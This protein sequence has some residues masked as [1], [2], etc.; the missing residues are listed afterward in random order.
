MPLVP[1]DPRNP[2]RDTEAALPAAGGAPALSAPGLR[3]GAAI[4]AHTVV[5]TFSFVLVSLMP[6]F[7]TRLGLTDPQVALLLGVGSVCSGVIQPIVAWLSD[8]YDTRV[9]GTIAMALAVVC[10]SLM[11]MAQSFQQL[12]LLQALGTMGVGA[13]HPPA[14]AAVGALAGRRRTLGMSVFFLA[15][16]IGGVAGNVLSPRYVAAAGGVEA[17]VWLII[18]GMLVVGVLA[19][20]IHGV[21]HR[22]HD[23]HDR[24]R[25]LTPEDRRERWRV[26]WLLYAGNVIR[27]TVNMALVY[28]IVA[29]SRR[30]V[31]G[32]VEATALNDHL[33][34]RASELNGPMQASMQVGMGVA[35]LAAG[36][37]LRSH[38]EKAALVTLPVAGAAAVATVP[39]IDG[40]GLD[41]L[42]WGRGTE[43]GVFLCM[44]AAG[45]GFGGLVPVTMAIAQRMLP[46]RTSLASG[47]MLG[48]AWCFAAAGPI[49]AERL[50]HAMG[51]EW[52]FACTA[53]LLALA[54][55]IAAL[56]P[57]RVLARVTGA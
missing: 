46:H 51:L 5:D 40:W 23:A 21:S 4:G 26:V 56:L 30:F 50:H 34:Q 27:F 32:G 42:L 6:V 39:W 3:A 41:A 13:F 18:P 54:G 35:G 11:G 24:H 19:L 10:V 43:A 22:A 48:G 37:V 33:A 16:M 38:H 29:W 45:V 47:L 25:A 7:T 17:L 53:G 28:L 14:A 52:A 49:L 31:L 9:F 20:A 8:R 2:T 1:A 44:V 15:G 36:L 57:G 55:L 12:L